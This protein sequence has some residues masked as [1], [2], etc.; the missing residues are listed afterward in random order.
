MVTRTQKR[1]AA[2][3]SNPLLKTVILNQMLSYVGAGHW[4]F[5]ATV[6]RPWRDAYALVA[7]R[8]IERLPFEDDEDGD[9]IECIPQMTLYSSIFASSSRVELAHALGV[10]CTR[11]ECSLCSRQVR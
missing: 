1:R 7:S 6:C 2:D 5:L 11:L 3:A 9:E 4:N 10:S 8:E